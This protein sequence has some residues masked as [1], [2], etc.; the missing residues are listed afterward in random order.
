M[1][2]FMYSTNNYCYS[3]NY[4]ILCDTHTITII[5]LISRDFISICNSTLCSNTI[6]KVQSY[7]IYLLMIESYETCSQ[8][9]KNF[10]I[11]RIG[12]EKKKL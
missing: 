5:S 11:L 2:L 8:K 6:P 7:N 1:D 4:A 12:A 10:S 3:Y 9:K